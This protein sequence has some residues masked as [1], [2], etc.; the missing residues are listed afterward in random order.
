MTTTHTA[1]RQATDD[2]YNGWTNRE[3][4][5][6]MLHINNDEGLQ[7]EAHE[8]SADRGPHAYADAL[9]T[10]VSDLF[11]PSYWADEYGCP[12]PEGVESMRSDVGSLW[13]VDWVECSTS[14]LS[15]CE[16]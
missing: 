11:T 10:W 4:W 1:Q 13:R 14:L 3:T 16:A 6:L 12:M 8:L 7:S 9:E 5:A 15:D 2:T